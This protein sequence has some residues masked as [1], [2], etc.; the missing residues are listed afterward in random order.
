MKC[1]AIVQARL[2]S[3]RLPNKALMDLGG[4]PLITHVL[5]RAVRIQ[6]VSKVVLAVPHEDAERMPRG[7][8]AI[9]AFPKIKAEDVLARFAAVH[10]MYPEFDTVMRLTGD[11]PL[12][13][14]E[15]SADVLRTYN[16]F[17][18]YHSNLH[19]PTYVDGE[20]TEVFSGT[21]L[22]LAHLCATDPHDHEHVTPWIRRYCKA[23]EPATPIRKTSVDTREDYERVRAMCSVTV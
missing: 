18:Q 7:E 15:V 12:L 13:D 17:T 6:G 9:V 5:E 10:W 8:W 19:W 21:I 11:C 16:P 4:K 20:D 22:R 3:S 14:P 23:P 1:L 2:G